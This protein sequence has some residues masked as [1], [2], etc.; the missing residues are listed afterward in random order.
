MCERATGGFLQQSGIASGVFGLA[1]PLKN[2][3]AGDKAKKLRG[4]DF[5]IDVI[6]ERLTR[7]RPM[8]WSLVFLH[9]DFDG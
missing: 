1:T 7:G 9:S 2:A 6:K 8:L 3:F 5:V 4:F